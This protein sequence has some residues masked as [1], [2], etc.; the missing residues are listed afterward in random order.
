MLNLVG[1]EYKELFTD[2]G[3][4][5]LDQEFLDSLNKADSSLAEAL[6]DYRAQGLLPA[7][8]AQSEFLLR[9]APH[10]EQ[11]ITRL[12]ALEKEVSE[13]HT[14]TRS[15]DVVMEFKKHFVLRRARRY[16]GEFPE[17][18]ADLDQ[19]LDSQIRQRAWPDTD[20]EWAI[21][22]LGEDWLK[23]ENTH[24]EEIQRLTQWCALILQ[25]PQ[26]AL[27]VTGWSSFRLPQRVDHEALVPLKKLDQVPGTPFV[28]PDGTLRRRDS[29]HLTDLRMDPRSVQ[30]EVHYCLYCHDHDGDFCS[31]GFPEKKGVP[32]LGLKVDPLGVTLTGCPLEE[33]IS[34]MQILK[35]DGLNLAALAMAMVDNPMVPAT[36]HRIC[37]DCMKACVYQKQDPVNIPQVETRILTD[38]LNLPWG[39]ELYDLLTRWNP[40]RAVQFAAQ[41]YNGRKVLVAGMGPAGFTMA[42]HLLQ[43]GCAVVGIDG[44]KI[45]PLPETWLT[46][47]IRD[48][49]T[50][51]EDLDERILLGFGG[52]AEYG[53]TVRWDKNFLKLIYLTLARR[54]GFQIFGGVR[55][56]GT[57]TL[58][59][60]WSLGFDHV[61]IATGAGLP[62]VV[63]MGESLARGMRQASDF[64]MALQLTGAGKKSSLANLQVRLPA[65]VIGGGLTAVDTATEVQ[66]Y[67]IRQVEK[68]LERYE[69]M[70]Q[71]GGEEKMRA[72]LSAED[73][74]ILEEFLAH[75]RAV[76]QERKRAQESGESPNFVP[77][78]Q[79]WGGVTLAYRKGMRQSPAYT[80]N[81]EELIKAMEEGLYYAEGLD[82]LRAELDTYGHISH[83]VFRQMRE[84]EGRWLS[85]D[86]E[87]RLPARAVFIAAGTVPNTIYEREYPGTLLLDGDHFQTHVAH[88]K[89]ALQAVQVAEHC[90]AP[91]AG[92]FTSY[93]DEQAHRVSFIG[94]THPVFHG[95]VVKAIASAKA[96]YP[97]VMHSL[98][99]LAPV[100]QHKLPDFQESL[101]DLLTMRVLRVDRSNPA[102]TEMWIKAPLA[103][104]NFRPGQFF[105]LQTFES[106][107]PVVNN[108]RLQIPVLTVSGAGV[109]EDAVR[110]MVLQWGTGP[111]LVG[112]LEPGDPLILMGPTGAP[113]D[114]PQNKTILVVAGR[115]GAAVMLDIGPALRAAGNR[116]LYV[117]ALGKASELDNQAELEEAA[118]Q[119]IW[120]TGSGP[121][122]A[123]HRPQDLSVEASD[124]VELLRAYGAAELPGQSKVPGAV[125]L[126]Q[127]DRLMVMG[128]TGLLKGFQQ[129]LKGSLSAYFR[130]DLEAVA[131]VGSPMQ[132]MLKGVCAQCLQWQIDPETGKRTKAVFSCAGQDQPLAWVD[133]DNLTARQS[134][135]RL[136]ERISS[137][138]LDHLRAESN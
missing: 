33:K 4:A 44:L 82:P 80:R 48:W 78:I 8:K 26:A 66:A 135:N 42:Q 49:S 81:H 102:V 12:F 123:T 60:A 51:Q 100:A 119:I 88:G 92:P 114:I 79:S 138:W 24:A 37:N 73:T 71:R 19:W 93:T 96:S 127:V 64:L 34:E 116:V 120:C 101:R 36:G 136:L 22:R 31:R 111:R 105:R 15:H 113:T 104:R 14:Q 32:E 40:L 1:F 55:L 17:T 124:M 9:L 28:A 133:L 91:E 108:T 62:R 23:D 130:S 117:A 90:K 18:F 29:F 41:P 25:D 27:A 20:R 35:R 110:L 125:A 103:A 115:W 72:G 61:C 76:R 99:A 46:A 57:I 95:S 131:T 63:P 83:M 86:Q 128:S 59:D 54:P 129:A 50:L 84:A 121:L 97:Q 89:S 112:S 2:E 7:S 67:Y 75:G 70:S 126:D 74:E 58:E 52:V 38:V 6:H 65:V 43:E 77:L 68:V 107:S 39:I 21:S 16:R 53:I 132:C 137:Q 47:P 94:D 134:Q 5:R 10:V 11:F 85:S 122:I 87:L 30:S 3:I 118:D 106:H 56:G 98:S 45:E 69:Q 13:L 109:E